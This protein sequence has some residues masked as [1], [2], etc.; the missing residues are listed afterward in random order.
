[1]AAPFAAL[2]ARVNAAVVARLANATVVRGAETAT[3][4]F[5]APRQVVFDGMVQTTEPALRLLDGALP[6]LARND[7]LTVNGA[8]YVVREV[9]EPDVGMLTVELRKA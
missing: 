3:A 9:S 5:D 7:A 8:A 1:M 4:I 2:E 6:N